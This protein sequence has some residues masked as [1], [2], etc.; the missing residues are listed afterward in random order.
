MINETKNE[1]DKSKVE[2]A[3]MVHFI[4]KYVPIK[5]STIS[6]EFLKASLS[7]I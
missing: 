2:F 1:F 6:G 5:I 4:D 7:E 3:R